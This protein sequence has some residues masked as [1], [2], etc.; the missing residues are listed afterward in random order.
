MISALLHVKRGSY[1]GS[2]LL[3]LA[4]HRCDRCENIIPFTRNCNVFIDRDS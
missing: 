3:R 4:L 2:R 1:F